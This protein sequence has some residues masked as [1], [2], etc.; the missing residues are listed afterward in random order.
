MLQMV[1]LSNVA[2]NKYLPRLYTRQFIGCSTAVAASC[3]KEIRILTFAE[4]DKIIRVKYQFFL[5]P[6]FVVFKNAFKHRLSGLL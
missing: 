6:L 5:N 4:I 2:V 1:N 3:V